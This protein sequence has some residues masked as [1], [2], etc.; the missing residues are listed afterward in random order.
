M[1]VF[2]VNFA[3]YF[4]W[5][6][7]EYR[8]KC[9]LSV[10]NFMILVYTIFAL[11]GIIIVRNGIYSKEITSFNPDNISIVPYILCFVSFIVLFNPL[12]RINNIN[13]E[14]YEI[15]KNKG[16][17]KFINIWIILFLIFGV[18]KVIEL[19]ITSSM[20][21]DEAYYERHIE[22]SNIFNYSGPLRYL[23]SFI[24]TIQGT[25]VP[26][27][28]FYSLV[29]II[30][31]KISTR[32]SAFL[33]ALCFCPELIGDI[34]KG[35]RGSIFMTM[36]CFIFFILIFWKYLSFKVKKKIFLILSLLI[37]CGGVYFWIISLQRAESG[38]YD[39]LI[40]LYRYFGEPFP[41][42][43]ILIWDHVKYNPNGERLF[44]A[45]YPSH[46]FTD[47]NIAVEYWWGKIGVPTYYFKTIFGDLYI[48]YGVY[49]T[50]GIIFI[51][52]WCFNKVLSKLRINFV[53]L[54]LLYYYFQ[55]CVYAFAGW[56]KAEWGAL[57]QLICVIFFIV[58]APK[59]IKKKK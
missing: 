54:P 38:N 43:G 17:R 19:K 41:N 3:L 25:T 11:A 22:G 34:A 1:I 52:S 33:I 27:V 23:N 31:K 42:L 18:I 55:I 49:K 16:I 5:F 24:I 13:I 30:K 59:F 40:T 12:K 56:T 21:L 53:T 28:M 10:Y 9:Q 57:Y 37:I 44:S 48:E 50:L 4:L 35:D 39:P 15:F 2:V 29:G 20:G 7:R 51:L 14:E 47:T 32:K 45:F 6:C 8:K 36:F 58:L 46:G 26:L